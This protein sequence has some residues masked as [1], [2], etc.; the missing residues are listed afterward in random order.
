MPVAILNSFYI[1]SLIFVITLQDHYQH[2]CF[3]DKE[4]KKWS[5][6]SSEKWNDPPKATE[7]Q[8]EPGLNPRAT[9]LQIWPSVPCPF[10]SLPLPV[11]EYIFPSKWRESHWSHT[12]FLDYSISVPILKSQLSQE[13]FYLHPSRAWELMRIWLVVGFKSCAGYVFNLA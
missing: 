3:R 6:E 2:H 4:N 7:Q 10:V 9:R 11:F 5:S 12:F 1:L 13:V 8:A